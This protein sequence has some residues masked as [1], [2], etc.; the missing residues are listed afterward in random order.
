MPVR[1]GPAVCRDFEQSIAREWLVTNGLGGFASG[2]VSGANSRRYHGLLVASLRPPVQRVVLLAA[3]EEWLV[4]DGEDPHPLSSQEYWDGTTYPDG[5]RA[6]VE[7]RL[8]GLNPVFT[9]EVAGR[10]IEKRVWMEEGYNRTVIS[11]RL[12][13]GRAARLRVR[14]L[15]AHRDFHAQRHG[16]D[17]SF[18]V[19]ETGDGWVIDG[20]GLHSSIQAQPAPFLESRPDWYWRILHRA[21]RERGL[22]DEE[23]LFTPGVLTLALEAGGMVAMVAG[24]DSLPAGWSYAQSQ[25]AAERRVR[26]LV[27]AGGPDIDA[28][29]A[30]LAAD[31]VLAASQFRVVRAPIQPDAAEQRTIIAGYHWFSDWGRDTMIS[32][33]GLTL[34]T[35][36]TADAR[37]I[38]ATFFE[39]VDEGMIPNTFD[40]LGAAYNSMDATL[41]LFQAMHAYLARTD[42]WAFVRDH[43]PQLLDIVDRHIAGT[44]HNIRM[45]PADGLLAGGEDGVQLTWMDAKVGDW[46]VTPRRG[47]PVEVNAL[48]YNALR[49]LSEWRERASLPFEILAGIAQRARAS[50]QGR[51]W[52]ATGGYLYDVVDGPDGDD[53]TLRPNQVMALSLAYPVFEGVKARSALDL[54]TADLLTPF[55]LRT[56][57]P[58]DRRY[59]PHYG[60][61]QRARDSAYHMGLVWPWLLGPYLDAHARIYG[62]SD[63]PRRLLRPFIDHLSTAGL[64]SIS[65]IFEPEP[66]FRPVGCIAQAWSVAELLRHA[67]EQG[68]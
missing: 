14:P 50:T 42:D 8:D 53:A 68:V 5:F 16:R 55:G 56:L 15:L 45:D 9:W 26:M 3:T 61:D 66:P 63:A 33:R 58:K 34:E 38:L 23:D 29:Q 2:T 17:G 13:E 25:H 48:W 4:V 51:F 59:Q 32:L 30:T 1:I 12:L 49:L 39:Y 36:S 40:D 6:L 35:G 47:K 43:L 37:D 7:V 41:W 20:G 18:E 24:T 65:E 28:G 60:G 64:G 22:D 11:Y 62:D 21:E 52:Y 27:G 54:I 10:T 67:I 31:L 46:V 44:R 19:A 57:T